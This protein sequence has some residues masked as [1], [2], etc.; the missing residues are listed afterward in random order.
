MALNEEQQRILYL[1]NTHSLFITGRAGTGKTF[2]LQELIR[3]HQRKYVNQG[4]GVTA[5]TGKAAQPLG[6][7]TFHSFFGI[8]SGRLSAYQLV[9]NIKAQDSLCRKIRDLQVLFI[10]EIS[11]LDITIFEKVEFICRQIR[12]NSHHFGGIQLV[13]CGDFF[14]LPPVHSDYLFKSVIFQSCIDIF[15]ELTTV[16]RQSEAKLIN[17]LEEA[18]F[19]NFTKPSLSLLDSLSRPLAGPSVR[20]Y[21]HKHDVEMY[22]NQKISEMEG[23]PTTYK[24]SD[25]GQQ[26]NSLKTC[27]APAT[28][29][30][31][32]GAPVILVKNMFHISKSLVNGLSGTVTKISPAGPIV[33]FE[34]GS[35]FCVRK[36]DFPVFDSNGALLATRKQLPLQLGFSLTIH[37]AQGMTLPNLQVSLGSCFAPGQFYVALS[38]ASSLDGLQVLPGFSLSFPRVPH[39]VHSFYSS[40]VFPV[41]DVQVPTVLKRSLRVRSSVSSDSSSSLQVDSPIYTPPPPLRQEIDLGSILHSITH[42]PF[43]SPSTKLFFNEVDFLSQ[44]QPVRDFFSY[45]VDYIDHNISFSSKVQFPIVH[46]LSLPETVHRWH[47]ISSLAST[48]FSASIP[49]SA[50]WL[51]VRECFN[52]LVSLSVAVH[53]DISSETSILHELVPDFASIVHNDVLCGTIRYVGGWVVHKCLQSCVKSVTDLRFCSAA[54]QL[55]LFTMPY[56]D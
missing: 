10:D 12:N 19:G 20:L 24:A 31:K 54:S 40:T 37:R 14:Q 5:S 1:S 48:C 29:I 55:K 8:G 42:N 35:L 3:H 38:R 4:V 18:R 9:H 27:S 45:C 41:H 26:K 30:L 46:F 16:H 28:L 53:A 2:L 17:L 6:G 23:D 36:C 22:N 44:P 50:L 47:K 39:D 7:F 34:D 49:R 11:M 33:S 25:S 43:S 51:S 52:F 13:V 15:V 56:N 21:S 32:V